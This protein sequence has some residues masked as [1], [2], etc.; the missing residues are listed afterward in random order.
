MISI[1]KTPEDRL[2]EIAL[3]D[4]VAEEIANGEQMR[5]LWFKAIADAEGDEE[6]A[7]PL[8]LKYRVQMIRDQAAVLQKKRV[9][10]EKAK[11]HV[12]EGV[13]T[14]PDGTVYKGAIG[15]G[16]PHGKGTQTSRSKSKQLRGYWDRG[17]YLGTK[18]PKE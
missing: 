14:Y 6:K 4:A 5:G 15:D 13:I 2:S 18:K 1:F 11:P 16:V 9:A 8:Y 12:S 10:E 3:Y 17:R 7:K